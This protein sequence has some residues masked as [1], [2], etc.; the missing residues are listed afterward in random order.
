MK[1]EDVVI[2]EIYWATAPVNT[3]IRI[4]GRAPVSGVVG[5]G[6][7]NIE[8]WAKFMHKWVDGPAPLDC[9]YFR[10][11]SPEDPDADLVRAMSII[12]R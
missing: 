5:K 6:S 9:G 2:G 12:E 11:V 8:L 10:P 4:I 1:S 7:F 3:F